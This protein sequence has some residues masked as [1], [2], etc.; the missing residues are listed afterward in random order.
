MLVFQ[1]ILGLSIDL[2]EL[3]HLDVLVT[4]LFTAR[5]YQ[6]LHLKSREA[7]SKPHGPSQLK[8]RDAGSSG[9]AGKVAAILPTD[10]DYRH[11]PDTMIR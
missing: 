6:P 10:N 11:I 5:L 9:P 1:I 3:I 4:A 7:A 8:A 2:N